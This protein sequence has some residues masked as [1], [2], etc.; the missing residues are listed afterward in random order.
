[1]IFFWS[2]R[3]FVGLYSP[4]ADALPV[5]VVA[6]QWMWTLQHRNGR[7]EI[8]ELHVPT[9]TP[10][11]LVMTSQDV[12]HSF[13]IPEL[14]VKQDVVPGRYT[15][16]WFNIDKPGTYHLYCAEYCGTEHSQMGG[17]V[18]ALPPAQFSAWLQHGNAR[19]SLAER[20]FAAYRRYGCS[21]CHESGA[22]VHAPSL[23]NLFGTPVQLQDGRRVIADESYLRD[24]IL[25]PMKDIVA[26]YATVMP[27][28]SGQ[29][30][31]DDLMAII[32]YLRDEKYRT[33]E[34]PESKDAP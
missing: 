22:S 14:R 7:R 33:D 4:P 10:I 20:G 18:T 27:N 11:K 26:G 23:R 16:L 24:S 29:M 8:N 9:D 17:V 15:L 32:D 30:S 6:K 5:F 25:L 31:E 13:F 21:G 12:I 34:Q 28:Y 2:V 3:L 19:S 1:G